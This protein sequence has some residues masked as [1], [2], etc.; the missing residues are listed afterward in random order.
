MKSASSPSPPASPIRGSGPEAR[1]VI[2]G[3]GAISAAG[4][5]LDQMWGALAEGRSALAPIAAWDSSAMVHPLGGEVRDFDPRRLVADRKA[6]KLIRRTDL[7]GLYAA[8]RAIEQS[9][10]VAHR[11]ALAPGEADEFNDRTG[12]FVGSG[13][14]SYG[15]QYDFLPLLARSAGELPAFG[16]D[17]ASTVS[18]MWLL[19]GLPNN[20][21]CH[22]GISYGF[23]GANACIAN[24]STSGALALLEAAEAL[25]N[26]HADRAVVIAHDSPIE[27]ERVR[28]YGALGLLTREAVRPFDARRDGTVLGEGAASLVLETE[29]SAAERRAAVLGEFLGGACASEAQGLLPV[30]A[31]GDGLARAIEA[32]LAATGVAPA[33][34]ALVVAHGNGTMHSDASEVAALRRV[35]GAAIPRLTAF[36]WCFGHLLAASALVEATL[37]LEALRRQTIPGVATMAR[38][39]AEWADLPLSPRPRPFRGDI[40]L[41][42]CRGFAGVNAALLVRSAA[43]SL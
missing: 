7:L 32:A 38:L 27:P 29:A 42:L 1:I 26:E 28:A 25:R 23:K 39:D 19:R 13:G 24:H 31:D 33:D 8:G 10:L 6:H 14:S 11:D 35:F 15:D 16:R 40:A 37:A 2:T 5:S 30:R 12:V 36:K 17:L 22:A 9:R 43:P 4:E 34:V 18:P 41:V 3:A 21:L 20:V